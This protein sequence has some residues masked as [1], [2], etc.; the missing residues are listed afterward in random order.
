M[1]PQGPV[2]PDELFCRPRAFRRDLEQT[3]RHLHLIKAAPSRLVVLYKSR[4]NIL[5]WQG[6]ETGV[7]HGIRREQMET[8]L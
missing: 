5:R 6:E 7:R 1:K 3:I 8:G 4:P 2:G